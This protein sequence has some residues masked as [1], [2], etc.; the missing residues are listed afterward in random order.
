M[1]ALLLF[2]ALLAAPLLAPA[3]PAAAQCPSVPIYPG[4]RPLGSTET[5]R[6]GAATGAGHA[7][8][9][10]DELLAYVQQFYY[11]RMPS[12]GWEPV[13]LLPGQYPEQHANPGFTPTGIT[14]QPVLEFQRPGAYARI[15]GEAG[16]YSIVLDCR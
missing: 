15:V 7:Y 2:A 5:S 13:T 4:S 9:A 10:T 11:M 8:Y 12:E 6:I 16:G 3:T 1:R 14:P